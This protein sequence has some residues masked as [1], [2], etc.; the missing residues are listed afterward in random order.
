MCKGKPIISKITRQ[1][2][3]Q[4]RNN[5]QT[6]YEQKKCRSCD[7]YLTVGINWSPSKQKK[8]DYI[9]NSCNK[10]PK[11][12]SSKLQS[13]EVLCPKCGAKMVPKTSYRGNFYGCSNY[14]KTGCKGTRNI[15]W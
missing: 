7:A 11:S 3:I 1:K 13:K 4:T 6:K 15:R 5:I 14:R 8:Y 2:K 10:K 9:C 12:L